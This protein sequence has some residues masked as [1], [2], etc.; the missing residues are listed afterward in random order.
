[1]TELR[2]SSSFTPGFL[3]S[4]L[5]APGD[6]AQ[7]LEHLLCTQ[8][9]VGSSPIVSTDILPGS[10]GSGCSQTAWVLLLVPTTCHKPGTF[11]TCRPLVA[12]TSGAFGSCPRGA[13]RSAI[14]TPASPTPHL[15]RSAPRRKRWPGSLRRKPTCCAAPGLLQT[16]ARRGSLP[17]PKIGW[18]RN[19][20]FDPAPLSSTG[21]FSTAMSYLSLARHRSPTS[22]L[23]TSP[24]GT[25]LSSRNSRVR[26]P[27][28]TGSWRRS[29]A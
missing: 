3:P 5:H 22:L 28:L 9:V 13:T 10:G 17:T 26:R 24:H 23:R 7:W 15:K 20:T 29:W 1:M 16:P 21:T 14:G 4:F 25:G 27:R 6:V 19:V 12:V 11:G 8:G 2:L 18:R